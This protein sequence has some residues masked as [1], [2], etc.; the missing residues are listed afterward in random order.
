MTICLLILIYLLNILYIKQK[1]L[2]RSSFV[3]HFF[4]ISI[5]FMGPAIYYELGFTSYANSFKDQ[6]LLTFE[7]YGVFVF[8]ACLIF[9]FFLKHSKITSFKQFFR[10]YHSGRNNQIIF[11]YF[12]FWFG[13]VLLYLLVYINHLPVIKFITTGNLPERFD[14]SDSVKLFYTFS[15]IFMV[16][17]PSGYFFII[18]YLKTNF[19]KLLL[20]LLVAFIL[21]SGGHKGLVAFFIIFAL[22]FSGYKFNFKYIFIASIALI[23]L[24][25]VYTL[26][27][28][29]KL[30]K[31]TIVYLLESPPR[32]FFV[33]QGSAFITRVSMDRRGLYKG[34]VYQYRVIKSETYQE[35]YPDDNKKGA[36]PTIFLGDLHVRYGYIF[37]AL[38]YILFLVIC[39]PLI[40]FVD[41]M[42]E[43]KLFV[44]WNV[45]VFF[46]LLGFAEL[47]F[48]S[49]LRIFLVFFNFIFLILTPKLKLKKH[50]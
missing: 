23:S 25:F 43:R 8:S 29:R 38:S 45:F 16:F 35:I 22:I 13:I 21:T 19:Q 9:L 6:D 36:A 15:S 7:R 17:I 34:D 31:E 1:R 39:F 26:T 50:E 3:I 33:T 44:W 30:N 2:Y 41:S 10:N 42:S 46:F 5:I 32:R 37:T 48:N 12:L 49:S 27:K 4:F 14:Q 40:K 11:A 47:S 20:L 18:Q 28:G 24:L